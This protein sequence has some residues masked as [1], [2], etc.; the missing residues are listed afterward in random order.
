MSARL[1]SF[2]TLPAVF[3]SEECDRIRELG[4]SLDLKNATTHDDKAGVNLAAMKRNCE[5]HFVKPAHEGWQWVFARINEHAHG[6]NGKRWGFDVKDIEDIQYTSYGFGEF[7]ASHFDNGS[8]MT[9]HRKLS[10]SVQLSPPKEYVGGALRF[11][12]MNDTQAAGKEQG[13]MTCF[14]AY[15]MHVAKPVW[16]GRREVLV[17]WMHGESRLR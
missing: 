4:K 10:I 8:T 3:T 7:Y 2:E 1:C 9:E 15:L 17:T 11:W 16:W 14:P 12:S 13:S 5:V 6:L